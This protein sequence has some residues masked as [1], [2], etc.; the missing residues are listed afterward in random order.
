MAGVMESARMAR[1]K[2]VVPWL[3]E[4]LEE[5]FPSDKWG[6]T[7]RISSIL[8]GY[9]I[10]IDVQNETKENMQ[11]SNVAFWNATVSARITIHI[12]DFR[13]SMTGGPEES[14]PWSVE[15]YNYSSEMKKVGAKMRRFSAKTAKQ[16]AERV[17]DWFEKNK[18]TLYAIEV[19]ASSPSRKAK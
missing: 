17:I 1:A 18:D 19:S 11:K 12:G 7:V 2:E 14:D 9:S 13:N 8:G 15:M 16:A 4:R 6:V 3:E 10:Y 5:M